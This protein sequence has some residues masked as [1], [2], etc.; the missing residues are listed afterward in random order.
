M[1]VAKA[2]TTRACHHCGKTSSS[3]LRCSQCKSAYYCSR[4]CQSAAWDP[5]QSRE[6]GNGIA[7]SGGHRSVCRRLRKRVDEMAAASLEHVDESAMATEA[8]RDL[9]RQVQS[10]DRDEA[11]KQMCIVQDE[12]QRLQQRQSYGESNHMEDGPESLSATTQASFGSGLDAVAAQEGRMSKV[13]NTKHSDA[14][15]SAFDPDSPTQRR[16]DQPQKSKRSNEAHLVRGSWIDKGGACSIEYLPNVKCYLLT[17]ISS[18][19]NKRVCCFPKSREDLILDF[20]LAENNHSD[21]CS[22]SILYYRAKLYHT[23]PTDNNDNKDNLLLSLVLPADSTCDGIHEIFPDYRIS[24]DPSSISIRIQFNAS[25]SKHGTS[26]ENIDVI[27]ELLGVDVSTLSTATITETE[28]LN[29]LCCRTC[30]N[31]IVEDGVIR[32]ALP[33]PSG[34]WDEITDY[35]ICYEGQPNVEFNS[36]LTSAIRGTALEDDAIIILHRQDLLTEKGGICELNI[37]GY[38]EYSSNNN[39]DDET[40]YAEMNAQ[41]WKDKSLRTGADIQTITCAICCSTLGFVSNHDKN[42]HR[43]YKHLLS[44]GAPSNLHGSYH[45]F[46]K[47]T[48]S[49]FLAREMIRYAESEA[50]YTFIV[51]SDNSNNSS[52]CILLR[53]L[54]WDTIMATVGC[55]SDQENNVLKTHFQKV[56]KVIFEETSNRNFDLATNN[57]MDWKW[58]GIDMCCPPLAL[59]NKNNNSKE[60]SKNTTATNTKIS[61]IN[62]Q[63]KATSVRICL[64][65]REWCEFRDSLVTKSQYFPEA[66]RGAAV[67]AKLGMPRQEAFLSFLPVIQ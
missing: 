54:S 24:I 47:H 34:Y 5:K 37:K 46:A 20:S 35:L 43:F 65:S 17:L 15:S 4:S 58:G 52:R 41:P 2:G 63:T 28:A 56:L 62:G 60:Q 44:C 12:I 57:P 30:H 59:A 67:M 66:I 39:D 14:V 31:P 51:E 22:S 38:G 11:Y 19:E 49:S 8:W 10:M 55:S 29:H 7:S 25:A 9:T 40:F 3:L 23:V 61:N 64:S 33:L 21:F 53:M 26:I 48:C 13:A 32:T 6:D 16:Q 1:P 45:R 36:S 50:I 18:G 27:D 42:T